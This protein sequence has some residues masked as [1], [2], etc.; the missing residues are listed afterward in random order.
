MLL[1]VFQYP[2]NKSVCILLCDGNILREVSE[3]ESE[4][5]YVLTKQ[6]NDFNISGLFGAKYVKSL[7]TGGLKNKIQEFQTTLS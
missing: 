7:E 5:K 1:V 2:V 4:G 6:F 3:I